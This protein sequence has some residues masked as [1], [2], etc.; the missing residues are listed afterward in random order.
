MSGARTPARRSTPRPAALAVA[1]WLC[2]ALALVPVHAPGI[3][4]SAGVAEAANAADS[5]IAAIPDYVGY[6][7][8]RAQVMDETSRAKLEGFL[9]QLEKKTGAEFAILTVPS[10]A[11]LTASEYKVKV[12]E[13]WKIGK[14]GKDNGLLMLVVMDEHEVR[15]ETGY[16]LEGVLPD[17]LLS[18]IYRERMRPSFRGGDIPGGIIAGT[19][20]CARLIAADQHVTLEWD[21]RELVY[22]RPAGR[23][24]EVPF[25][26]IVLLFVL[27]W[28]VLGTIGRMGG[29]RRGG[30]M[31]IGPMLGGG[32]GGGWGG[33]FGGGM[34]GG[35]GFGGF[36]GG[37][38]GGGGGGGG[39]GGSW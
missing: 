12:F 18:R 6:V 27:I 10:T 34:G 14:K 7:N 31:W 11:P 22:D 35:G 23:G 4:R 5:T 30:G 16:G 32:L 29:G 24:G 25:W 33:G 28:I 2:G 21:G 15:F 17:G 19:L 3:A 20:E 26:A 37:A 9:D 1:G 13:K 36:G 39:G 8:D 38:S